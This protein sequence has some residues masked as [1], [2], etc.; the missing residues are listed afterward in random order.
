MDTEKLTL[1]TALNSEIKE[2][3]SQIENLEQSSHINTESLDIQVGYFKTKYI[4]FNLFKT[5]TL[6]QLKELLVKKENEF[7]NL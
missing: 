3:K 1:A 7:F 6:A 5:I 2:I 4:D